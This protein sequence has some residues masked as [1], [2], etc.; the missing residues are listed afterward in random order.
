LFETTF[1]ANEQLA[2]FGTFGNRWAYDTEN[3][4]DATKYTN[5][6]FDIHV[7]PTSALSPSNTFGDVQIGFYDGPNQIGSQ[8]IPSS[9]TNGWAQITQPINP[10]TPGISSVSGIAFRLQTYNTSLN[11]TG[12]VKFWIDNLRMVVS[13][14]EIPPPRLS[15]PFVQP[16][17]GL[18][19]LSSAGNGNE[20]Q[21][22]SILYT[23]HSGV[24][25]VGASTPVT[26]AL[27]IT[28]FPAGTFTNYQAH[29][30]ITTGNTPPSFETAPDYNETNVIF[31]DV[32]QNGDGTASAYFRYKVNEENQ[33]SNMF[34][35]EYIGPASAG[36]LGGITN[37][38]IVG[39]WG[40]TFSQ[41]TNV[42]IFGPGG[43]TTNIIMRP[44]AVANFTEPLNVLFGAQ[45]N[46]QSAANPLGNV[47]QKVVLASVGITNGTSTIL[48]DNF[49]TDSELDANLFT[50]L[51]GDVNMVQLVPTG[52]AFWI[53]W[54][55][56]DAGFQLQVSTNLTSWV[57]VT[58]PDAGGAT[59]PNYTVT[60]SRY[61]LIPSSLL[62][63]S[64][65]FFRLVKTPSP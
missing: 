60:G 55:L 14:V 4:H 64:Q 30:F 52:S 2:W 18:N 7:D 12:H 25:W 32:H 47:G 19:L 5:I 40:F 36:T 15:T 28:N 29:I 9:A 46:R 56:P 16:V 57:T 24:G 38:S 1:P 21:R 6:V 49:I 51:A 59:L 37:S 8:T 42:T 34:G 43:V 54:S 44:Q 27:T 13:P 65:T 31:F 62:G 26:Y 23:E 10:A 33:N 48:W 3:R 45:P 11:P 39:T 20:F 41:D 50:R 53:K 22:T 63:S 17:Q 35:M 61:T 58:G